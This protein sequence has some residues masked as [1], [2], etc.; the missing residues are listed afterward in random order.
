MLGDPDH[1]HSLR[2]V[3]QSLDE[4]LADQMRVLEER[5]KE[6]RR[7]L[8]ENSLNA[9]DQPLA[10]SPTFQFV[11]EHLTDSARGIPKFTIRP[12][13]F[14]GSCPLLRRIVP[15]GVIQV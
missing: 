14:G 2:E 3:L 6:I 5:R 11:Q 4:E 12:P 9:P 15:S 1:E 7:L 13:I 8:D 10:D